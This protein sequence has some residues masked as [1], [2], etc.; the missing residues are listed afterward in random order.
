MK[1][2][3]FSAA[4]GIHLR[5]QAPHRLQL[6]YGFSAFLPMLRLRQRPPRK[7][8][9]IG[10]GGG[11]LQRCPVYLKSSILSACCGSRRQA[12]AASLKA[13]QAKDR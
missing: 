12:G 4:T 2:A 9:S 13:F 8:Y 10:S 3:V 7:F 5:A 6:T 11:V 1:H